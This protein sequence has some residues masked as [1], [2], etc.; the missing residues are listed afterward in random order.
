MNG[1]REEKNGESFQKTSVSSSFGSLND[2]K[3]EIEM[4]ELKEVDEERGG[5]GELQEKEGELNEE[6]GEEE[7]GRRRET[8]LWTR[9]RVLF[10]LGSLFKPEM[11]MGFYL[12]PFLLDVVDIA[13]SSVGGLLLFKQIWDAVSDPVVGSLSD[14]TRSRWGRFF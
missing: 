3:P 11:V 12:S 9:E 4:V 6:E 10:C 5:T 2:R 8:S 7:G 13:P 1:V 14:R